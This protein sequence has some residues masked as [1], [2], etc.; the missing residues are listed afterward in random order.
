MQIVTQYLTDIH[1]DT[2]CVSR[3]ARPSE[4]PARHPTSG[5]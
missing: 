2:S 1:T 4:T 3:I 5:L